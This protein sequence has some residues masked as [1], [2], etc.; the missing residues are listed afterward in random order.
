VA[1]VAIGF[2]HMVV[3]TRTGCVY[4]S[5]SNAEG[6]LGLGEEQPGPFQSLTP[7]ALP[8]PDEAKQEQC[9]RA[10]QVAAGNGHTLVLMS[11]GALLGVGTAFAGELGFPHASR[12]RPAFPG[13][14][15]PL[16]SVQAVGLSTALVSYSGAVYVS[17]HNS[18]GT[19][20][21]PRKVEGIEP[22]TSCHLTPTR[23]LTMVGESG[24]CY[25]FRDTRPHP[26]P[27]PLGLDR[28]AHV[29]TSFT[30]FA[31]CMST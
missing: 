17:G 14:G 6:Q 8:S 19:L 21:E 26:T 31:A 18:W 23:G 28:V 9:G 24:R 27:L 7:I 25:H 30:I 12:L 10:V 20:Y 13:F 22:V 11:T 5:G 16:K 15:T 3:V 1:S 2:E 4:G 29:A